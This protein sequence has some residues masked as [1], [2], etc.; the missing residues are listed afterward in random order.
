MSNVTEL[1][2]LNWAELNYILVIGSIGISHAFLQIINLDQVLTWAFTASGNLSSSYYFHLS[3][4]L[5]AIEWM[6][7]N[8]DLASRL[9]VKTTFVTFIGLSKFV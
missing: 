9:I 6:N 4:V 7:L 5:A 1:F 8:E 3:P 2:G